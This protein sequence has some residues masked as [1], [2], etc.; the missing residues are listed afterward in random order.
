MNNYIISVDL[1]G[2]KILAALVKS[3]GE[4]VDRFK[5]ATEAEKGKNSLIKKLALAI[6]TVVANNNLE[7]SS[8]KAVCIGVPGSVDPYIGKIGTAPN[9]NIRNLNLK[10]ALSSQI[11]IPVF[12]END[13]NLAAL[14]IQ[15]FELQNG[16]KNILVVFV[17]TGIGGAFIFNG[18]I[19]RGSSNFA[20]EIGHM[21]MVEDGPLC[22]CGKK[23][24]FEAVASRLAIVRDIK[25]DLKTAK[26]SILKE[27]VQNKKP[28]KS[29][30]IAAGVKQKD[31]VVLKHVDNS[32]NYIG[33]NIAN[34]TNLLNIDLVVLGGGVIEAL[35]KYMV[36]K[37]KDSFK[38]HV[39]KDASKAVSIFATKLGDDAALYG[40]VALAEEFEAI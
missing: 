28:I 34:I 39:L 38:K 10:E 22:G 33:M 30:A 29:K 13:V 27:Y 1:G 16:H 20:G 7:E 15:K 5:I 17:G 23:G 3:T 25:K 31:P 26:K 4:I 19:F 9:L 36:P 14:G 8:I 6:K 2:T 24:C 12:I 32:C 18:K 37:I 21:T 11:S 40:G 35:E